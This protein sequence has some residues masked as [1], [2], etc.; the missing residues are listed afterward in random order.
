[1]LR[2]CRDWE[3]RPTTT[4]YNGWVVINLLDEDAVEEVA[5][6]VPEHMSAEEVQVEPD[7]ALDV[8]LQDV[9]ENGGKIT[10]WFFL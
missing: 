4:N 2:L 3:N 9:L 5:V 10:L 8:K 7:D 1:M 6:T